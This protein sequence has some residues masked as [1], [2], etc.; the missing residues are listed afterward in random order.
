MTYLSF[1]LRIECLSDI[2]FIYA[3]GCCRQHTIPEYC[4]LI[5]L[6]VAAIYLKIGAYLVSIAYITTFSK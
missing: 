1:M 5:D 6:N 2:G 4:V 3:C